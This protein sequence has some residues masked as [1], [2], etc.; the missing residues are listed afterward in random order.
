MSKGGGRLEADGEGNQGGQLTRG[1]L[2]CRQ[3]THN[4]Q[5]QRRGQGAEQGVS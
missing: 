3:E 4:E 2:M 5:E 1:M